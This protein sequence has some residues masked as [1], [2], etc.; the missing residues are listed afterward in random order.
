MI[1]YGKYSL[2]YIYLHKSCY[3]SS[4]GD[5][6]VQN[7]TPRVLRV[8]CTLLGPGDP[9][10]KDRQLGTSSDV[11]LELNRLRPDSLNRHEKTEVLVNFLGM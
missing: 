5:Q 3:S 6:D 4:P 7:A 2:L 1:H 10:S 8:S 11:G 9:L